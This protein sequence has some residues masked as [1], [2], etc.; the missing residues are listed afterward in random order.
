M[1]SRV[2]IC[3]G[4][5]EDGLLDIGNIDNRDPGIRLDGRRPGSKTGNIDQVGL[6]LRVD[7]THGIGQGC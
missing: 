3:H 6:D 2:G 5:D 7:R 4:P 1:H